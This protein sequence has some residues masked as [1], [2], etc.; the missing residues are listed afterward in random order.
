MSVWKRR[1][2]EGGLRFNTAPAVDSRQAWAGAESRLRCPQL[3]SI[4][5]SRRTMS[6]FP[7]ESLSDSKGIQ[8]LHDPFI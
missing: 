5:K 6:K 4:R 2:K 7:R 8:A 3:L 1:S